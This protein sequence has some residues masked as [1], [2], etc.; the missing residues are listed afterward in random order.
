MLFTL[1]I[2]RFNVTTLS[3]P[4]EEA[5][6]RPSEK[7]GGQGQITKPRGCASSIAA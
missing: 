5:P 6:E 7:G 3:H 4:F 1:I 2:V